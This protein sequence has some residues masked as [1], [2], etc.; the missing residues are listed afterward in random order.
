MLSTTTLSN[1]SNNADDYDD[2]IRIINISI[3]DPF[4]LP[5][6]SQIS[7]FPSHL[8]LPKSAL[9]YLLI[10]NPQ[11]AF[12]IYPRGLTGRVKEERK[13]IWMAT[14]KQVAIF[15]PLLTLNFMSRKTFSFD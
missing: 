4:L 12:E 11:R 5:S 8:H 15:V 6:S 3:F 7:F 14:Q 13:K 2:H 9:V 10:S 1:R